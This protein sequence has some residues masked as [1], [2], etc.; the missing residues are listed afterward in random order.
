MTTSGLK[1]YFENED[2]YVN[3]KKENPEKYK[4]I[5]SYDTINLDKVSDNV[6][7]EFY[8]DDKNFHRR[9]ILD[10]FSIIENCITPIKVSYQHDD[11]EYTYNTYS[12]SC[13][14]INKYEFTKE[15]VNYIR[16][17]RKE[18]LCSP[19]LQ[20]LINRFSSISS[21]I[22]QEQ[23]KKFNMNCSELLL[24]S[25]YCPKSA[26]KN[27]FMLEII[28]TCDNLNPRLLLYS[29]EED[30][31]YNVF[32]AMV[33]KIDKKILSTL[34]NEKGETII[35]TVNNNPTDNNKNYD[36][37]DIMVVAPLIFT[38]I[39]STNLIPKERY[40]L[41]KKL[42]NNGAN[43]NIKLKE[44]TPL[45]M[46]TQIYNN[47]SPSNNDNSIDY[48]KMIIDLLKANGAK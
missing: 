20:A 4:D 5:I 13:D 15:Q 1:C 33:K 26:N 14:P 27:S 22:L 7:I 19:L 36:L 10:L 8:C 6:A 3:A 45:N 32:N 31:N 44:Y 9:N 23:I 17:R 25:I 18:I 48:Q 2:E 42:I 16:Q 29:A 39:V 24:A 46:A 28:K 12:D 38:A 34:L 30:I 43:L 41:V 11:G 47:R 35:D 40:N 37:D 21:E